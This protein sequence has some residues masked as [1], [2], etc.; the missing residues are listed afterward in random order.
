M[1]G[2]PPRDRTPQSAAAAS[3]S[4][5]V[6]QQPD[7]EADVLSQEQRE[8]KVMSVYGQDASQDI[9]GSARQTDFL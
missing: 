6:T 8:G 5:S 4:A 2:S 7:Q 3:R 9:D 1:S